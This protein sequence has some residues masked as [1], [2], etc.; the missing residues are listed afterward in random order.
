MASLS[1]SKRARS[2]LAPPTP[3]PAGAGGDEGISA[4]GANLADSLRALTAGSSAFVTHSSLEAEHFTPLLVEANLARRGVCAEIEHVGALLV[5]LPSDKILSVSSKEFAKAPLRV[6]ADDMSTPQEREDLM[7]ELVSTFETLRKAGWT[8]KH[9]ISHMM[10]VYWLANHTTGAIWDTGT[11]LLSRG[12]GSANGGGPDGYTQLLSWEDKVAAAMRAIRHDRHLTKDGVPIGPVRP[13]LASKAGAP[14]S[15][16]PTAACDRGSGRA[17]A[18]RG[19]GGS[20]R[21]RGS[22]RDVLHA[23]HMERRTPNPTVVTAPRR[24]RGGGRRGRLVTPPS[25]S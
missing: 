17:G 22:H 20:G 25:P 3:A 16:D 24:R 21:G 13:R 11:A 9:A 6:G 12:V 5:E 4:L 14:S 1:T 18:A 8:L 23:S 15:R 19:R 10:R 2:D 7:A